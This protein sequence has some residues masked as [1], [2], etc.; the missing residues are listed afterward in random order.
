MI[1]ISDPSRRPVGTLEAAIALAET[2]HLDGS[3]LDVRLRRGMR[4]YPV[5]EILWRRRIPFRFMTAYSDDQIEG[6]PAEAVQRKPLALPALRQAV[7]A[8]IEH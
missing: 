7:E 4:V 8:L 3:L 6:M 5:V 1:S 2:Q